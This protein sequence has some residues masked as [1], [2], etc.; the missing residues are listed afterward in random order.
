MRNNYAI[1]NS[2]IADP[3]AM[4]MAFVFVVVL[5]PLSLYAPV[6]EIKQFIQTGDKIGIIPASIGGLVLCAGAI[7]SFIL[8]AKQMCIRI[9]FSESSLTIH[10]LFSKRYQKDYKHY[11][12]VYKASYWHGSPI[13]IGIIKDYIVI[14][15]RR[16][17]DAE[18]CNI[19]Q[20][21]G[22]TDIIKIKYS[23][24][25]YRTLMDTLPREMAYKL[26]VCRFE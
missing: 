7:I 1:N 23:P 18:L 2:L 17:N 6:L 20:V 5:A 24:K 19:N 25:T 3:T 22:S 9:I 16:L 15:H 12:Y 10:P 14:S 26:K 4:S 13:G 11:Q 8:L 21:A